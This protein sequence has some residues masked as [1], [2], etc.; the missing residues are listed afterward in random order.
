MSIIA[1]SKI[2]TD[3]NEELT[4]IVERVRNAEKEDRRKKIRRLKIKF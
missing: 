2:F 3:Q 1:A 4:F